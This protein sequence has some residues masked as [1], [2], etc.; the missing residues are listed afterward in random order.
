MLSI[1]SSAS[2]Q[3]NMARLI[4]HCRPIFPLK[5]ISEKA[6]ILPSLTNLRTVSGCRSRYSAGRRVG[7]GV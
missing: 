1:D 4:R 6:G 2:Q 5:G 3:S 7:R